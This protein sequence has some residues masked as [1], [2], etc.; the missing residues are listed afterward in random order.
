MKK[1]RKNIFINNIKNA[2]NTAFKTI[3]LLI[4][5]NSI[6][7]ECDKETPILKYNVCVYDYCSE[8]DFNNKTSSINNSIVKTQWQII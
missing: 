4:L 2:K 7:S 6:Q 5:F 1:K 8:D 3:Y